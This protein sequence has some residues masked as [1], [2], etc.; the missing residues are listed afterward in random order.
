MILNAITNDLAFLMVENFTT[1]KHKGESRVKGEMSRRSE[2]IW[3]TYLFTSSKRRSVSVTLI[4]V[5]G[6]LVFT[7]PTLAQKAVKS[8]PIPSRL[9]SDLKS[10]DVAKRR[11]AANE[12][13][14]L[15]AKEAVQPLSLALLDKDETVRE[16]AAF[17]LG[18][19]T[20][21]RAVPALTKVLADKDS[22][23]RAAAVFSLGM[24]GERKSSAMISNMLDD[25]SAMVRSAAVTALG[26][27]EDDA[28]VD[29]LVDALNDVSFD[30]RYDTVWA[31]GQIGAEDAI[32]HLQAAMVNIDV[33]TQ[34]QRMR[35]EFRLAVQTAIEKIRAQEIGVATRPRK[36][37][38]GVIYPNRYGNESNPIGIRQSVKLLASERARSGRLSGTVKLKVLVAA[39]GRAARAY[40]LKRAGNGLDQRALQAVMQYK[41]EPTLIAGMPQTGWIFI[42]IK[43]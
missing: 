4:L 34:D 16:A 21:P 33:L 1:E 32:D 9:L 12:L 26:L 23:V 19:I 42:D 3:F 10:L 14:Y 31:L 29:E 7:A 2:L 43:F 6:A 13:C 22:E 18:Q 20:D 40:I 17:A 11:D 5:L 15:R 37:T 36:T 41:F 25:G 24:I 30:V 28:A 35:E 39:D 38:E 27:M 8:A